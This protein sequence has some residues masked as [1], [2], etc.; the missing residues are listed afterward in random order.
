VGLVGFVLPPH[1]KKNDYID[2]DYITDYD[3]YDYETEFTDP[4]DPNYHDTYD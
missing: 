2:Y 1:D 3:C 4:R